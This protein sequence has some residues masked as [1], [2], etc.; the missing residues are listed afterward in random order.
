MLEHQSLGLQPYRRLYLGLVIA[1]KTCW[2]K[3]FGCWFISLFCDYWTWNLG[4]QESWSI[5]ASSSSFFSFSHIYVTRVCLHVSVCV[6]LFVCVRTCACMR[7]CVFT[8]VEVSGNF[9]ELALSF[10]FTM[11]GLGIE[12]NQLGSKLL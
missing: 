1:E 8:C 7:V 9:Q 11:C 3:L 2:G 5:A 6:C 4:T 12:L 10:Q